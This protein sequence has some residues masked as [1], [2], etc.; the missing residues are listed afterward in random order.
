MIC[1]YDGP[2]SLVS[3]QANSS[4]TVV[5]S[6]DPPK[7]PDTGDTAGITDPI[8]FDDSVTFTSVD[9]T[10]ADPNLYVAVP[11]GAAAT[12]ND[13]LVPLA[14]NVLTS[15]GDENID[16]IFSTPATAVG[17]DF[18]TNGFHPLVVSLFDN[19]EAFLATYNLL[20]DGKASS[21]FLG[22]VSDVPIGKVN[23]H[24]TNGRSKDTGIA[25]IRVG[26]QVRA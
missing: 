12:Q 21:G 23:W 19:S 25:N 6:F 7:F 14:S 26:N 3:F 9:A 10:P 4:T 13:F 1:F 5:A 15:N 24:S 20:P 22:I 18:Y 16:I 2:D 17:F 11:G 8:K